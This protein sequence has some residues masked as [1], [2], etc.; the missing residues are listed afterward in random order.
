MRR[1]ESK[2]SLKS[3]G[4]L[5]NKGFSLIELL[6]AI[7]ILSIIVVPLLHSF[8]TAAK[9][10]SKARNTMHATAVAE[11]VLEEFEA[12]SIEEMAQTYLAAGYA[13][14]SDAAID[15]DGDGI[16]EEGIWRFTGTDST[17]TSGEYRVEITLD[18]SAY[19]AVN[20]TGLVDIQ[21]L[22]G[23]LNAVYTEAADAAAYAEGFFLNY[24]GTGK[25]D[26]EILRAIKR[27]IVI[28]VDSD[29]ITLDLG[30]GESLTT[31]VYLVSAS[32]KYKCNKNLLVDGA[33]GE[34]PQGGSDYVIF[35]NEEA[36]RKKADDIK[37]KK[38]A[39]EELTKDDAVVSKLANIVICLRPRYSAV[40]SDDWDS[41][42][43]EN[44]GN[45]D[46]NLYLVKQILSETEEK[47]F[48]DVQ[49]ENYR[50]S[51]KLTET[52]PGWMP[53][54]GADIEAHCLLRTNFL[55]N[56]NITYTYRNASNSQ[57]VGGRAYR[58]SEDDVFHEGIGT[59]GGAAALTIM[60]AD[61]LTPLKKKNR[62][63]DIEVK[64]YAS[65][66]GTGTTA[67]AVIMTGTVTN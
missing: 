32:A 12:Y 34:Y 38:E 20:E 50:L 40:Y 66:A 53:S 58:N 21:N 45:V 41:V 36:V 26:D 61:S 35:S 13:V 37:A 57:E 30:G 9:T 47:A 29:E 14:E 56:E 28:T 59:T 44:P 4:Q 27:E 22:A 48:T 24:A 49:K 25:A 10:N 16:A 17:T 42:I 18:P 62:I 51:F 55:E 7:V 64:I 1:F 33:P 6:I 11:N 8:V 52:I 46:T 31:D 43:V 54:V 60:Q 67:P 23:S 39:G 5:N 65:G 15:V 19:T 2:Q 63:Y 3:G